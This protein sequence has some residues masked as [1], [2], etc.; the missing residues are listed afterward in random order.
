MPITILPINNKDEK[1]LSDLCFRTSFVYPDP[2]LKEF[3]NWRWLIP[4]CR[5]EAAN[6]FKAYDSEKN[7]IAGY[8]LSTLDTINFE[9][10]CISLYQNDSEIRNRQFLNSNELSKE[11]IAR[12]NSLYIYPVSK[13]EDPDYKIKI[14][15]PA[16]LHIDVHPDYQ[17]KG[18]GHKLTDTLIAHLKDKKCKG[19][20]LSVGSTNLK[21]ISFYKK[22]GFTQLTDNIDDG[23]YFGLKL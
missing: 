14:E 22:Y 7:I 11:E 18:L 8:I 4:Y 16:H 20:H 5:T 3:I 13:K 6:S 2:K 21:G 10:K 9:K 23:I 1:E 17:G 12:F 15:Y 19:L